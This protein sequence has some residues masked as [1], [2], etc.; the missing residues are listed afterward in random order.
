MHLIALFQLQKLL[1]QNYQLHVPYHSNSQVLTK[2]CLNI[3]KFYIEKVLDGNAVRMKNISWSKNVTLLMEVCNDKLS[4]LVYCWCCRPV[5][6]RCLV[7]ISAETLA[8][9]TN[10]HGSLRPCIKMSG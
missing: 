8:V 7:Q 2:P 4:W 10:V 6:G 1:L 9:L 5:F 3:S